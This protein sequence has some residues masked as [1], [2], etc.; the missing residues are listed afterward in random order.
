M[1]YRFEDD[2]GLAEGLRRVAGET[3]DTAIAGLRT[4]SI[5]GV[6]D[7][8]TGMKRARA[9][10]RLLRPTLGEAVFAEQCSRLA[11]IAKTLSTT[12]DAAVLV[13]ILDE[14]RERSPEALG[15][16]AYEELRERFVAKRDTATVLETTRAAALGG[17]GVT[18]QWLLRV[19][20]EVGDFH[21]LERGLRAV[22][23][24]GRVRFATARRKPEDAR[25][26]ALRK[27]VKDLT[28]LVALL[29][30]L[31]PALMLGLHETL[32]RIGDRLGED[33]DLAMLRAALESERSLLP[34]EREAAL[35][36][37]DQ[38]RSELRG[39]AIPLLLRVFAERPRRFSERLAA[40]FA[41]W[42]LPATP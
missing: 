14:L 19:P 18:K 31:W 30:P 36:A 7:A 22:Y 21:A 32:K 16:R 37:V 40:Y 1:A 3:L 4:P 23:R 13:E 26:H 15:D 11:A 33:R 38:R 5:E 39:K 6:H 28:Y 12:R 9:L 27:R 35:A 8:R 20:I 29:E 10:L 24:K 2:E 41:A 17:L 25:W 42:K 34:A